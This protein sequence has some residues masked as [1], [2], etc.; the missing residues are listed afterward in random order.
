MKPTAFIGDDAPAPA[1]LPDCDER[2]ESGCPVFEAERQYW[3]AYFK[4]NPQRPTRKDI[5]VDECVRHDWDKHG[6]CLECNVS[7]F[8][9]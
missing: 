2:H 7:R 6:M 8:D 1:C 3:A 5:D 9:L 4:A